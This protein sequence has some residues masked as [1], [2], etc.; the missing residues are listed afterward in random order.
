L[1]AS[2][3]ITA[4]A[5]TVSG[6]IVTVTYTVSDDASP[7]NS[8]T[9]QVVITVVDNVAPTVSCPA[10]ITV[11]TDDAGVPRGIPVGTCTITIPDYV[12]QLTPSDNCTA[13][14]NLVESQSITAGSYSV[15][16]DGALVTVTYT[17]SDDA[18]P[19]NSTTCTIVI[20]VND[21]DKPTVVCPPATTEINT[22]D[23]ASCQITIPDY[24]TLLSP[25]DNCTA[26][27]DLNESQ[28]VTAGAYT[29]SADGD[30]VTVTYTVSDDASPSNS[31]S[32]VVVI[33]VND[34]GP[35]ITGDID[36][37]TISVCRLSDAPA[38]VTTV[39]ALEALDEDA[40]LDIA[41]ACTTDANLLVEMTSEDTTGTSPNF[42]LTRTYK[43]TDAAGNT[44][45]VTQTVLVKTF[46]F[47]IDGVLLNSRDLLQTP[48]VDSGVGMAVVRMTGSEDSTVTTIANG[49]YTHRVEVTSSSHSVTIRPHKIV[50]K[51]NGLTTADVTRIQQHI[52]GSVPFTNAYDVVASDVNNDKLINA[53]DPSAI[54]QA[55]R[56]NQL[57][58]MQIDSS[59]RFVSQGHTF[60]GGPY[61][62]TPLPN[63]GFWN[64]PRHRTYVNLDRDTFNQNY[65][66][67][68]VGDVITPFTNP[69]N[70]ASEDG[71]MLLLA[72]D[73]VLSAGEEVTVTLRVLNFK[74]IAA[75]QFALG[76]DFTRLEFQEV[77]TA[78]G[79]PLNDDHFGLFNV[80]EGEIRTIWSVVQG[81]DVPDGNAMIYIRFKAL[82]DQV[83]LSE[84]LHLMDQ[85]LPAEAYQTDLSPREIELQFIQRA[86]VPVSNQRSQEQGVEA[87]QDQKV[88]LMQNRPN[89]FHDKTTIGFI[90]SEPMDAHLRVF[91][92]TGRLILERGAY[93]PAGYNSVELQLDSNTN[94]G[95]LIY[96]LT[97]PYGTQ[98]R[99]MLSEP[100][101]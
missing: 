52:V 73:R 88:I 23:G 42:T 34:I 4:G 45:E 53:A 79:S 22:N 67:I 21:N 78:P 87:D 56:G 94:R 50:N 43:V 37:D 63:S 5:Y 55:L 14:P 1:N 70:R 39:D 80:A 69:G 33:T 90:L 3:D 30:L 15:S 61:F 65:I 75:M 77:K 17:V 25:S 98:S 58:F 44:V 13:T 95:V 97:T 27:G 8:T 91:D 18:S 31:T 60:Q 28:D 2:Q 41:D 101:Q 81:L 38:P 26:A 68:K 92:L 29:V 62:P 84:V 64:Y 11:N 71:R 57:A 32:C 89:A 49:R 74:D 9:C 51:L 20:T 86:R 47:I 93:Y 76:F 7:A 96:E 36:P 46:C 12:S 19:A 40:D 72:N 35:M 100:R 6:S 83:R 85:V 82:D 66:G 54:F 16:G 99:K 24:V 59:W 48:P 10:N